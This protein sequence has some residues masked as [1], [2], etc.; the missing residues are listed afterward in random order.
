MLTDTLPPKDGKLVQTAK[1]IINKIKNK[2]VTEENYR[3]RE[4]AGRE[5]RRERGK[6]HGLCL[7]L[8][9]M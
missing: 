5:L 2:S 4:E 9:N 6:R 1:Q 7:K 8:S 3:Y